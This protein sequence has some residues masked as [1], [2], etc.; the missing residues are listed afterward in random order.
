MVRSV[1]THEAAGMELVRLSRLGEQYQIC[2][3]PD[4]YVPPTANPNIQHENPIIHFGWNSG[5]RWV[6]D[7]HLHQPWKNPRP[8]SVDVYF[9]AGRESD[10]THTPPSVIVEGIIK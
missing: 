4:V 3:Y 7:E 1:T 6:G 5:Y 8:F 2:E 10:R 9:D